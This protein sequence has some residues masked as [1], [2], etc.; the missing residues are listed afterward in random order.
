M[1]PVYIYGLKITATCP[2]CKAACPMDDPFDESKFAGTQ[3]G[4]FAVDV[5]YCKRVSNVILY[6]F[7]NHKE[8]CATFPTSDKPPRPRRQP[9]RPKGRSRSSGKRKRPTTRQLATRRS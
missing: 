2:K 5:D 1:K 4:E 9:P 6:A 8:A 7:L 3:A